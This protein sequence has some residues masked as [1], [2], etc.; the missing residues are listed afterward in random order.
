M[1]LLLS[2]ETTAAPQIY[3]TQAIDEVEEVD[4]QDC[5]IQRVI[6]FAARN[7]LASWV[8]RQPP[9]PLLEILE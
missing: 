9:I 7:D 2:H 6:K 1:W 4:I 5:N 3:E 8:D